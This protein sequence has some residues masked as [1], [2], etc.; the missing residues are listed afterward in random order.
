[1]TLQNWLSLSRQQHVLCVSIASCSTPY[2]EEHF[3]FKYR[4]NE[5]DKLQST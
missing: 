2:Q 4:Q 3:Q 5:G 1:M